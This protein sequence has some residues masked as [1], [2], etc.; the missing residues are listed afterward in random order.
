MRVRVSNDA[1]ILYAPQAQ[2]IIA[3]FTKDL[4]DDF[5]GRLAIAQA[6]R[7]VFEAFS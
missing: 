7:A 5:K 1:G 4:A 3:V 6:G 2:C